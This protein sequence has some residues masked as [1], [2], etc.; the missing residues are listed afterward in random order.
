MAACWTTLGLELSNGTE[1]TEVLRTRAWCN[2]LELRLKERT[3]A[4][5]KARLDVDQ[6]W[7]EMLT[8]SRDRE[9]LDRFHDKARRGYDR[10]AQRAEQKELDELA[11]SRRNGSP[12]VFQVPPAVS[13]QRSK[14]ELSA[15]NSKTKKSELKA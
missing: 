5:E 15:A 7:R 1:S 14:A 2:V 13:S 6:F 12:F 10:D 11:L 4:L 8:A 9:A 3:V